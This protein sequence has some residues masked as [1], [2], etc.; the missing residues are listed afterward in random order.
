RLNDEILKIN[1]ID[2]TK[3]IQSQYC[4]FLHDKTVKDL[5]VMNLTIRRDGEILEFEVEK[6]DVMKI[7][8]SVN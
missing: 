4:F 1:D 7:K 2:F 3:N 8:R 5:E 6:V